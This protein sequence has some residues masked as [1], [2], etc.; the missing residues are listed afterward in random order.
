MEKELT[1]REIQQGELVVLKKIKEICEQ[2][3]TNYFL[4]FGTLLG[5]IRHKGIIPWDDDID[6]GMMRDDYEKF[7]SYCTKHKEELLPFK[8][9]HYSTKKDYIYPIARFVDTRYKIDYKDTVDYDLGLFVDVYP[10]DGCG[11][12]IEERNKIFK[13]V[14]GGVLAFISLGVRTNV[15]YNHGLLNYIVK[16]SMWLAAKV[17]GQNRMIKIIEKRAKTIC[18][19]DSKY[20]NCVIWDTTHAKMFPRK[21]FKEL[22]EVPFGDYHFKIPKDFDEVLKLEYDTY[23]N[24]PPEEDRVGHH[25]YKAYKK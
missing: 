7:I 14:R 1:L 25:Y 17:I 5:A 23:M 15:L 2:S 18:P 22:I 16:C 11:N 6:V 4:I 9:Y 8:L 21:C 12:T 19:T 10:F 13:K 3:N 24:L 20:V